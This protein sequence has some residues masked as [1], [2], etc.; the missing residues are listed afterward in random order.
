MAKRLTE[1]VADSKWEA[2][3]RG[4]YRGKKTYAFDPPTGN[5]DTGPTARIGLGTYYADI[6]MR[7]TDV[8]RRLQRTGQ[9]GKDYLETVAAYNVRKDQTKKKD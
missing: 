7:R 6:G 8:D 2:P 1:I 5:T 9:T 4:G 3:K